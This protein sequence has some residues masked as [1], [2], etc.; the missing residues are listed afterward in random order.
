LPELED[1]LRVD[2]GNF[3][4]LATGRRKRRLLPVPISKDKGKRS[5]MTP[6]MEIEFRGMEN[7]TRVGY[8]SNPKE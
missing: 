6:N 5:T 4:L 1:N 8:F 7:P 3:T 2:F